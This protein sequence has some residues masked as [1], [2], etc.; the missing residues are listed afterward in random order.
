MRLPSRLAVV[1][2]ALLVL[3]ARPAT[4][5][6]P[7]R[8]AAEGHP[9][10]EGAVARLGSKLYDGEYGK[11]VFAHNW[12]TLALNFSRDG[13]VLATGSWDALR[14]WDAATGR[15]VPGKPGVRGFPIACSPDGKTFVVTTSED[16]L[17]L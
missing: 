4:A 13:K 1:S 3:L 5:D 6:G 11:R 17:W 14:Q 2:A 9:L 16:E 7:P 15:E 8:K 12:M 10:P